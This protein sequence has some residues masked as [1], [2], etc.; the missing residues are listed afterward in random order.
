DKK[1]EG[2]SDIRDES[3]R[4]GMRL[5]IELKRDAIPHVVLN[6]LYK[7]T[8]MQST[9]G[10]I[11]LAL[12]GGAPR[13]MNLKELL[14]KY[15]AHR[16]EIVLRRTQCGLAAARARAHCLEGLKI[17]VDHTGEVIR[18][19]RSSE[20]TAQAGERLRKRFKLSE[21]QSEAILN[22]PLA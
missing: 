17:A 19:I 12:D 16:H 14:E 10:V 21:K 2:I 4:D 7:H 8:A 11:M 20:D 5:V 1:L 22:M 18:I 6:Q 15:L 3:D 9:F 13:V